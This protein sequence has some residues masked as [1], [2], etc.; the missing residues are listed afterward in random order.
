MEQKGDN[1][2]EQ[3]KNKKGTA[4]PRYDDVFK[5]GA[6]RIVTEQ[7][8]NPKEVAQDSGIYIDTLRN[9]L[10]LSGIEME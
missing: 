6:I 5:A 2:M 4:S 1:T 7:K 3:Q 8:R 10:K 9:W